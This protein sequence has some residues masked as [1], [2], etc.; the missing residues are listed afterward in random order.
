MQ[1]ILQPYLLI[2][3]MYSLIHFNSIMFVNLEFIKITVQSQLTRILIKK[4]LLWLTNILS[5]IIVIGIGL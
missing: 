5:R 3:D 1:I 2:K 4:I